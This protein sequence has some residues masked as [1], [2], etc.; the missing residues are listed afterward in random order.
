MCRPDA[1]QKSVI[2]GEHYRVTERLLN[3]ISDNCK[4]IIRKSY[5]PTVGYVSLQTLRENQSRIGIDK[6]TAKLNIYI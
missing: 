3:Q 5:G 2:W 4:D 6:I 1:L